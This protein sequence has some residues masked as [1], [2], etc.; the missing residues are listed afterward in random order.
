MTMKAAQAAH[1][2]GVRDAGDTVWDKS[3]GDTGLSG[4]YR[5]MGFHG[6]PQVVTSAQL[7]QYVRA[8]ERQIFRGATGTASGAD[9]YTEAFRSGP[10]HYAGTGIY[11][12]GTYMAVNQGVASGYAQSGQY[13]GTVARMTIKADAKIGDYETIEQE[14]KVAWA[15]AAAPHKALFD[16]RDRLD[17]DASITP[18]DTPAF[19]ALASRRQANAERIQREAPLNVYSD[20]GAY[21]ASRGYDGYRVPRGASVGGDYYVILNRGAVRVQDTSLEP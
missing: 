9:T 4:V 12:N 20:V 5:A 16:E 14:R 3:V 11:G 13:A 18:R 19:T 17:A 10:T 2:A 15:K 21:A 7:D 1:A 6:K 8:G